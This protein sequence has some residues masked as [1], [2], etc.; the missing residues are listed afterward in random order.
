MNYSVLG[1]ACYPRTIACTSNKKFFPLS[2]KIY[3][4]NFNFVM[5]CPGS[6]KELNNTKKPIT[7]HASHTS[8]TL[9]NQ[10]TRNQCKNC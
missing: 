7:S 4:K 9:P 10:P 6:S 8:H 1:T 2:D 5:Q 3:E